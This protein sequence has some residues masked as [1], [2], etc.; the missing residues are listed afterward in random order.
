MKPL[1]RN[2]YSGKYII[3]IAAI[4]LFALS[5]I[6]NTL[7]SNRSSVTQEMN[8]LGRHLARQQKDFEDMLADTA[9]ISRLLTGR[10][11]KKSSTSLQQSLME[12]FFT[13][14]SGLPDRK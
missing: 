8:K 9:L 14:T 4:L 11:L 5:F 13:G 10:K 3:L 6:F 2:I 12:Y 7:Y 1:L